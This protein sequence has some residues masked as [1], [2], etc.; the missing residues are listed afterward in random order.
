MSDDRLQVTLRDGS[1]L[2][3]RSLQ[4]D[5]RQCEIGFLNSL[6]PESRYMRS[7][8]PIKAASAQLVNQLMDVDYDCRMALVA[9]I[10]C[11]GRGRI[12]GVARYA[13]WE[14]TIPKHSEW[15]HSDWEHRDEA[16]F[17]VAV[18]D[19][20]QGH[21]VATVLMKHLIPYA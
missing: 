3:V 18:L 21:E 7:M 6:S 1:P 12:I 20:W 4:P 14:Q 19:V 15:E 2:T 9:T 16:E 5:D 10:E 13:S 17:V 8:T 11:D